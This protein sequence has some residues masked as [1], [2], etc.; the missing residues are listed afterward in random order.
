[1]IA[2]VVAIVTTVATGAAAGAQVPLQPLKPWNLDYAEAQC[3]A[4]RQY[5]SAADPITL[6]IRPAPNGETFELL[7]SQRRSAPQYAVQEDG[8]VSFGG[9]PIV[10][11]IL[12]YRLQD[13]PVSI[14]QFRLTSAQMGEARTAQVV[15]F[16]MG[17]ERRI[18]FA[19]RSMPAILD[20]LDRCTADLKRYWNMDGLAVGTVAVPSKGDV[21]SVFSSDDYPP[22]A[23]MHGLE[24]DSQYLLLVDE[25]G[26]VAA[27]HLLKASGVPS[28]DAMGCQVLRQRAKFTPAL[29][30]KGKPVRSTYTTPPIRW[31]IEG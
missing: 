14:H 26:A 28:I 12:H 18:S 17:R 11:E 25:R 24:G 6:A 19:L 9:K 13:R 4:L 31:R 23:Y 22:A 10:L 15:T 8:S 7:V 5:G 2:R 20:G 3:A 29:D 16:V 30:S 1:M 27:C 21:R